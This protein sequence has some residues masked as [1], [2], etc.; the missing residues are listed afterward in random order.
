MPDAVRNYDGT[1][2]KFNIMVAALLVYL[3]AADFI[4]TSAPIHYATMSVALKA[5]SD[6]SAL[7]FKEY[8][9]PMYLR[10][11]H[12]DVISILL[13]KTLPLA[14]PGLPLEDLLRRPFHKTLPLPARV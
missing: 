3:G 11:A 12:N 14:T 9:G 10:M 13:P 8:F 5:D 6:A 2:S 4:L 1:K 7:E